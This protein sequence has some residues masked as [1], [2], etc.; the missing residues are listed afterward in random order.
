ME[1]EGPGDGRRAHGPEAGAWIS[2]P[3]DEAAGR[4][5]WIVYGRQGLRA[6]WGALLFVTLVAGMALALDMLAR[7]WRHPGAGTPPPASMA[8][9]LVSELVSAF[10][11]LAATWIMSRIEGRSAAAYGFAGRGRLA[12]FVYGAGWGLASLSALVA[13][14][15]RTHHLAFDTGHAGGAPLWRYGAGWFAVFLLTGVFE[16]SLLRGYLQFTLARG[17]GFWWAALLLS[18]LFGLLHGHNAGE[19]PVGL[20]SA[21][22]VGMVLCISLWFTGSLWWAI[23]FHAAWDWGE[24]FLFGTANSGFT[25]AGHLLSSRPE[26]APLWSG[27]ATGP[28]GSLFIVPVLVALALGMWLWWRR[29]PGAAPESLP[30]GQP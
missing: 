19:S 6:G 25:A 3:G 24:T 28:E 15:W 16:E 14:L 11:V 13:V 2:S 26:G 23:G 7:L 30:P 27:G 22:A 17:M 29:V 21:A 10:V 9:M 18:S 12:R 4:L 5:Q 1:G 8:L 20:F